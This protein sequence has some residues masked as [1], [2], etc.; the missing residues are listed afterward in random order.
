[1]HQVR[2]YDEAIGEEAEQKQEKGRKKIQCM[3]A[4]AL[5]EREAKKERRRK[6]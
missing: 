4:A 2:H 5:G 6:K 3:I 1:M